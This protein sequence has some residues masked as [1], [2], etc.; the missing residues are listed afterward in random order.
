[1]R[2]S[3]NSPLIIL[4]LLAMS[5][6]GG[7]W[8]SAKVLADQAPPEVIAF[9]RF[10]VTSVTF[11]PVMLLLNKPFRLNKKSLSF[12]IF[13]AVCMVSYNEGLFFGL[14]YGFA[15][16]GG[17]LVTT[18]NPILTFILAAIVF[19]IK[20]KGI[21]LAGLC[22]G[23][24]GGMVLLQIWQVSYRQLLLS[25]NLFFIICASSWAAMTIISQKS[26]D[27]LHPLT[28][29][30]YVY[31]FAAVIDFFLAL[32]LGITQPLDKGWIY[33][34][35]IAYMSVGATTFATTVYFIASVKLGS[36]RAS[37]FIFTVPVTAVLFAWLILGEIPRWHIITGGIIAIIA[38]YLLNSGDRIY[39]YIRK[40]P[41]P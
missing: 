4:T 35:N 29:S 9:W 36:Q 2:K 16:A 26:K 20:V 38:V 10:F 28:F 6:W 19:R 7:S 21:N 23:L 11:I 3:R 33:W 1:M 5:A 39:S 31:V 37:S 12:C 18:L 14:R 40:S 13:G 34:G 27:H 15:S 22:I 41:R 17:V 30:F 8:T 24:A 25:G 32:K